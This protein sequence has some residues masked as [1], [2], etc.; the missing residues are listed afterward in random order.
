LFAIIANYLNQ[1][2]DFNEL[3]EKFQLKSMRFAP[4]TILEKVQFKM[5]K[6]WKL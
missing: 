3:P 4:Q 6:K 2:G 1:N 5:K